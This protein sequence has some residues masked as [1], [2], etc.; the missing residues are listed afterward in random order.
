MRGI[1]KPEKMAQQL[2]ARMRALL[3]EEELFIII[4]EAGLAATGH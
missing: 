3:Q 4:D 2:S 1:A